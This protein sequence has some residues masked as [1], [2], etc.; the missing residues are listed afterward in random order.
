M[1]F[2]TLRDD[3]FIFH[4]LVRSTSKELT[5]IINFLLSIIGTF[6]FGYFASQYAFPAIEMVS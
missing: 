2:L 3:E 6:V 5:T 4:V 1:T